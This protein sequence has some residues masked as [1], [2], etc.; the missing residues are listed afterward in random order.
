MRKINNKHMKELQ[1]LIE[2][3]KENLTAIIE[4]I[5]GFA[6]TAQEY[7]DERSE[8]WHDSENGER[9]YGWIENLEEAGAQFASIID[10][11]DSVDILEL[12]AP[13][14]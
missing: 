7:Y 11:L 5:E 14:S 1:D 9:Y 4:Q 3:A 13:A 10:D 12:E 6:E 2:S 8:A